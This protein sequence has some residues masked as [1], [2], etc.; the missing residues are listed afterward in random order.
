MGFDDFLWLPQM[1]VIEKLQVCSDG[2]IYSSF[3]EPRGDLSISSITEERASRCLAR[4][5]LL[6]DIRGESVSN[7]AG[8]SYMR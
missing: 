7:T 4:I 6:K 8:Y 3:V 5:Q 1:V 2:I